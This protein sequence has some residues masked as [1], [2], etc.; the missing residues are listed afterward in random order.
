MVTRYHWNESYDR[1][2]ERLNPDMFEV[3]RVLMSRLQ[4]SS[5]IRYV[6]LLGALCTDTGCLATVPGSDHQLMAVDAGHL[7]P[8]GSVYVAETLL[9]PYLPER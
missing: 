1:V 4:S 2:K 3:D 8:A 6:S 5:T 7:T 9:R